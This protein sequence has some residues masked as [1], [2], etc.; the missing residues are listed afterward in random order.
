MWT[1]IDR[2]APYQ[3]M[4]AF[5]QLMSRICHP[6]TEVSKILKALIGRC[7]QEYPQQ[8]MWGMMAVS[9]SADAQRKARC[10]EILSA[11]R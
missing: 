11:A 6:D 10:Q 2:V 3:F 8:A 7:L 1:M 9:R 4:I 5:S